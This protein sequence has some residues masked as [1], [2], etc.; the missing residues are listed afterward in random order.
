[1]YVNIVIRTKI[2]FYMETGKSL[3]KVFKKHNI[4]IHVGLHMASY[5]Q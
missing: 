4:F 1:M 3:C 2:L 5:E